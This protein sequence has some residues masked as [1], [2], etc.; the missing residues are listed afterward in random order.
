MVNILIHS[1]LY[2]Y[3]LANTNDIFLALKIQVLSV[4]TGDEVAYEPMDKIISDDSQD[5][6]RYS[7]EF[8]NSLTAFIQITF[9]KKM[10]HYAIKEFVPP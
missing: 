1:L 8:L 5:Q 4:R 7:E 6:L 10:H 9:K 3:F 2:I